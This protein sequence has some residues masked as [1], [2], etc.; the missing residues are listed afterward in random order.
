MSNNPV[1]LSTLQYYQSSWI[2]EPYIDMSVVKHFQRVLE[3]TLNQEL[4]R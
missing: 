3:A 1:P 2:M 4:L